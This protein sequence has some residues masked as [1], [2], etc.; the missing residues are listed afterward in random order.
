M[1]WQEQ[2]PLKDY[3]TMRLGGPA[4]YL[5]VARTRED[6]VEAAKWAAERRLPLLVLGGGSNIIVRDEGFPGLVLLNHLKGFKIVRETDDGAVIRVAAGENWDD[7]VA[8]T[9]RKHLSGIEMLS[10]I[11]GTAGA[12]PVQN[13]GAYGQELADVF[14]ELEAYDLQTKQFVTLKKDQCD[15]GYRTSIFKPLENRR[16]IITSITLGLFKDSPTPPF[17]PRL[18]KY[19]DERHVI[20]YTPHSIREAVVAIRRLLL[21]D[22]KHLPNSGSFF[23]NPI[24]EGSLVADLQA[25][26]PDMP[27][28]EQPDGRFKI[29][30]GWLLEKAGLRGYADNGMRTHEHNALV[31]VNENARSYQ[32]LAGFRD[33]I[34]SIIQTKFGVKLEQEPELI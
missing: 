22:P 23:K 5:A 11:P 26:Y 20:E 30:A 4:R 18:Q 7:T 8:H 31:F 24:V 33:E 13:V 27:A 32:D 17:Y 34:I 21:P 6:I 14:I 9:V 19:L 16:Y 28:Y 3:A 25:R 29:P 1:K 10:A 12:T 15:F 2:V